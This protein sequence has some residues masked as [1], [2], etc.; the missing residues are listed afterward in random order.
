[1]TN[2]LIE[3]YLFFSGRCEEALE[4]YKAKLGAQVDFMMRFSDSPDATPPDMLEPGFEN[5]VMHA[6]FS[7]GGNRLMASDGCDSKNLGFQGFRLSLALPSHE[8]TETAFNALAEGGKVD[9]PL[10]KTFWSSSF[11]MVTDRFGVPWMV[12]INESENS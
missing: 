12:S 3:P 10:A 11:G 5:K 6:S 2:T 4:F 7:I 8:E 9:M 1:M